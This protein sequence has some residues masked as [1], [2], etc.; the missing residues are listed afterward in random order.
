MSSSVILSSSSLACGTIETCSR[1]GNEK[2]LLHAS[3]WPSS[4]SS[5]SLAKPDASEE[6]V[7]QTY[8]ERSCQPQNEGQA[9]GQ[10]ASSNPENKNHNDLQMTQDEA[11]G[12]KAMLQ[13]LT[14]EERNSLA[15][16]Y[17]PLRHFRA[18]KVSES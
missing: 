4:S 10:H 5:S 2:V 1:G 3:T 15:D 13:A 7:Q 6:A 18:E 9:S 17:M 8:S 16:P 12:T 11:E 14:E